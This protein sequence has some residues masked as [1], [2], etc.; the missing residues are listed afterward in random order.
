MIKYKINNNLTLH[1]RTNKKRS[2]VNK[3]ERRCYNL[4]KE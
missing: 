4:V 3:K 2:N 1:V